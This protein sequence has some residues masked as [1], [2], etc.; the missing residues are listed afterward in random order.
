MLSLSNDGLPPEKRFQVLSIGGSAQAVKQKVDGGIGLVENESDVR[1][2][3][4]RGE[5]RLG[6]CRRSGES[7]I[8]KERK[9]IRDH[10]IL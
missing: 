1:N 7:A 2:F 5:T 9:N 8:V 6:I 3:A 10:T 4:P